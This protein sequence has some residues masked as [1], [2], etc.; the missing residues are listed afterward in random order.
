MVDDDFVIQ[1]MVENT[2]SQYSWE[3]SKFSNG[4]EFISDPDLRMYDLIFLDLRMP[5][6]DGFKVMDYLN[7]RNID[8]PIIILSALSRKETV[9]KAMQY[10]IKSYLTKPIK[11]KVIV[12]KTTEALEMNF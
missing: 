3:V 2:F 10:G 9:M 12:Q 8:T 5:K 4:K 7:E 1:N 11:P 6:M